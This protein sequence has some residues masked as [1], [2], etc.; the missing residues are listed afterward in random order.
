MKIKI[1]EIPLA[2]VPKYV[3]IGGFKTCFS[4]L[5]KINLISGIL[6]IGNLYTVCIPIY[7]CKRSLKIQATRPHFLSKRFLFFFFQ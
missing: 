5:L 3:H 4:R 1:L 7:T 2:V 6:D